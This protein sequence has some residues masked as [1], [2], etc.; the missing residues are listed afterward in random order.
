MPRLCACRLG[1]STDTANTGRPKTDASVR[2]PA[3][4]QRGS[5][6][7]LVARADFRNDTEDNIIRKNRHESDPRAV[8]A[9]DWP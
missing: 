3:A 1:A 7:R 5:A 4:R 9:P 2:K 6:T 8:A